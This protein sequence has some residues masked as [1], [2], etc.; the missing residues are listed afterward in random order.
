M[1]KYLLVLLIFSCLSMP[2]A[3]SAYQAAL[4]ASASRAEVAKGETFTYKLS[5]IEEGQ[6]GRGA[7]AVPPDFTGFNVTGTFSSTSVKVIQNKAR[8][9]SD[10]EYRMSSDITGEHIIPPAKLILT[11]PATGKQQELTSNPVKVTVTEKG[12]GLMKGVEDEI[13]DIKAPKSFMDKVKL[14]F[15]GMVAIVALILLLIVGLVMYMVKRK[16]KVAKAAPAPPVGAGTAVSPRDEAQAEL[17]RADLLRHDPKVYYSSVS[18]TVRRY[19]KAVKG[20]SATE[21]TTSELMTVAEKAGI[22]EVYRVR[23]RAFLEEADLVKFAKFTPGEEEKDR[24][25]ET[26]KRLVNDI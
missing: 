21:T 4:E 13:N 15:Y 6:A 3:A 11:D 10:T 16:K 5:I 23:L 12:P 8:S 7:Q 22:P 24:F 20:V 1:K 26:A 25:L 9:V 18:G 17:G 14:F 2:A 19:L